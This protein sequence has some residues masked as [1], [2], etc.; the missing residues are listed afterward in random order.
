MVVV[1]KIGLIILIL[2]S[3]LAHAC[4]PCD[5]NASIE[6]IYQA[7]PKYSNEVKSIE[8]SEKV[9]F[10]LSVSPKGVPDQ[11]KILEY[12]PDKTPK[13]AIREMIMKSRF[14]VAITSGRFADCGVEEFK[15]VFEYP[16]PQ[17]I[18]LDLI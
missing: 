17:K 1:N 2:L 10:Q 15:M 8:G 7:P 6:T 12:Y 11:I 14:R 3:P 13:E 16:L 5:D 18:E 4:H 9:V